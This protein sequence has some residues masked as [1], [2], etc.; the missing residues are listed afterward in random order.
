MKWSFKKKSWLW[1]TGWSSRLSRW[2]KTRSLGSASFLWYCCIYCIRG[3]AA[4]E[5]SYEQA[6]FLRLEIELCYSAVII[7]YSSSITQPATPVHSLP[8]SFHS[9]MVAEHSLRVSM[10]S[11]WAKGRKNR[12]MGC[13]WQHFWGI[14]CGFN[15]EGLYRRKSDVV[16]PGR[17]NRSMGK[18]LYP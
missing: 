5:C 13:P 7:L 11:G 12:F 1:L 8:G 3:E 6:F 14:R 4:L 17:K 18:K 16:C 9:A 2:L 15:E 10:K